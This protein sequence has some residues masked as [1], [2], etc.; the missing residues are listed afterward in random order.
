MI[1][2]VAEIQLDG[3]PPVVHVMEGKR[4]MTEVADE[5]YQAIRNTRPMTTH[6][7]RI[8][9]TGPNIGD[10]EVIYRNARIGRGKVR[11][12]QAT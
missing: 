11:H 7:I 10:I 2:T 5:L 8:V 9:G 6:L 1:R 4:S 3:G 12:E